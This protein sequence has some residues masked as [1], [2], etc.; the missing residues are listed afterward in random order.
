MLLLS[1]FQAMNKEELVDQI[2]EKTGLTKKVSNA[3]V[4]AMAEVIMDAVSEGDKVTLVG[5]GTF[6]ARSRSERTGR[7]P[8]TGNPIT[9]PATTVP[10]F[11][12]GKLF[13]DKVAPKP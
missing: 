4:T 9:I 13:K 7:N 1:R 12:A 11:S 10:A 2:A 6:E 5:F 3:V 8:Q